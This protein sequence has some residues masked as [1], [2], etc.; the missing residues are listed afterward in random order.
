MRQ[1]KLRSAA[2]RRPFITASLANPIL[3]AGLAS[4]QTNTNVPVKLPTVVVTGESQ[5]DAIVQPPFLPAVEGTRIYT[6]KKTTVLDFDAMPL[7]QSDNYRQAFSKTPGLLVSELPNP[8]LLS[9]GSRGIG[10]PHETQ[11]LMVLRDGIPFAVDLMGYPSVY[12]AP[13][14]TSVDRLEFIRGGA[15][16]LYGPQP[17]GA[18]NYVTHMPRRDREFAA[19]TDQVF[20]SDSL[21]TT[22][23]S[24]EGT[25]GRLGYLAYFDHRQGDSF[26]NQN[27]DFGVNAGSLKLVLDAD[28]ETRWIFGFDGFSSDGGEPGGLSFGT[29]APVG[30]SVFNYNTDRNA[31]QH[32]FDRVR[33]QRYAPSLTLQHDF[34]AATQAEAKLWGGYY[35]RFSKRETDVGFGTQSAVPGVDADG[36]RDNLLTLH[37]YYYFGSDARVRHDWSAWNNDH[38]LTTGFT[39][40]YSDSPF[41]VRRGETP[42]AED[43]V[44]RQQSKRG[45]TYA[46]IFVENK[47]TFDKFSVVPAIRLE[48]IHQ[49]ITELVNNGTGEAITPKAAL[50]RDSYVEFVPLLALGLAYD[51]G[52]G[53]E[54]YANVSEGYKAK[55][56]TDAVP[57]GTTD[58]VSANLEPGHTWTYEAGLRGTPR[59]WLSYDA[60]FFWI[61]YDN[62]FGRIGS[63][64]QNVGR[65]INKGVDLAVEVDLL[66]LYDERTGVKAG[67][68][69]L[70]FSLYGNLELL[71]ARF[72]SG[73]LTGLT[74]QYAPDYLLRTG[75]MLRSKQWGRVGLMG[76][77]VDAH[78]AND[79]NGL[80]AAANPASS[81]FIP[82]YMVWDLTAEL[83]LHGDTVSVIAG[84]NNL[85]GEDYYSRIRSDGIQPAYGRNFYAG[86]SVKF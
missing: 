19:R 78:W 50:G 42:N 26:R 8:A 44:L 34:S 36:N 66:G 20:G 25:V 79:N 63:N 72:E 55:T 33:V 82:A 28:R 23:T 37:Q 3:L 60:S 80:F 5:A 47:F 27:S 14:L 75:A 57:L 16:L 67:E 35:R 73:P 32:Q 7:I 24:V 77:F 68:R 38:T 81:G 62:R 13:P 83:K 17:G 51:L 41:S 53:H 43:G 71:D 49:H 4:A 69:D 84:I 6:G 40:Y 61:D 59:S 58:T 1:P 54:A 21:Y 10:D 11:D 70:A 45:T 29:A 31:T 18:L 46:A 30:G 12:Y 48:A 52:R 2:A 22:Y 85:L 39:T 15:S 86:V 9:L 64:F 76:T 56:F 74:P 65:S